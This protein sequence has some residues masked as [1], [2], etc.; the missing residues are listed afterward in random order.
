MDVEVRYDPLTGTTV[1]VAAHR[2]QRPNLPTGDCPFCVGGLEAAEPYT[3]KAFANRWPSLADDRCEIVLYSHEHDATFWSMGIDQATAVVDLWAAR[4]TALGSRPDVAYVLIGE[5]R[6]PLVGATISHPHGQI[7]AY[8]TVPDV[9]AAELA[10]A[11][12]TGCA[13]CA[14]RPGERLVAHCGGWRAWVPHAALHPYGVVLAPVEHEPDLP[15]L[16]A[17]SRRDLAACLAEVLG[18]LDHLWPEVEER[19]MPSM[20]WIHQRPTGG[21]AWPASHVHVEIAVPMRAPGV[22]RYVAAMELGSGQYTN[23][24]VPEAAAAELRAVEVTW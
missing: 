24:L 6:G 18:R 3:V 12:A 13:L 16:G 9:P 2:Q 22:Q 19:L 4:T 20:L 1:A 8:P 15:A 21:G 5:N 17:A 7:Y 10:R 11:A 23:P 14:E